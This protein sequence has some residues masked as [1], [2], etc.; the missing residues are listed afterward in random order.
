MIRALGLNTVST[1]VFWSEHEPQPGQF[2]F[3]GNLDV[4]EFCRLAQSESPVSGSS[5]SAHQLPVA[6]R[7]LPR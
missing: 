3:T 6:G 7:R 1:Y 2:D 4:G 5:P